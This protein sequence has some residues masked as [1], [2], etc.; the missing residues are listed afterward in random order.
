MS[1]TS[2]LRPPTGQPASTRGAMARSQNRQRPLSTRPKK[3]RSDERSHVNVGDVERTLSAV[4]GGALA[5]YGLTRGTLGGLFLAGLGG[6]LIYRGVTGHC[7]V[8]CALG[9]STADQHARLASVEAGA[10]CKA[11]HTVTINRPA[12]DLY[13]YWSNFQ[14]LP[15]I[16]SHLKEVRRIDGRRSHWVAK[17]PLGLAVEWDAEVHTARPNELISWRSLPGSEVDT[18]G[19]VHFS[20][21]QAGRATAVR[22]V[23]KY[24][25]PAG[26]VGAAI[27]RWLGEDPQH[28]IEN[29]L[30]EFKR[31]MEAGEGARSPATR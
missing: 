18:A 31:L 26:K 6:G 5:L 1:V 30:N 16:M 21:A 12:E 29:D 2:T 15:N 25:P 8:Y 9:V 23:L 10:G 27:A 11:E 7:D 28:Q 17:A 19:S 13:V 3:D 20:P 22:V 4:G 14:N 24:D